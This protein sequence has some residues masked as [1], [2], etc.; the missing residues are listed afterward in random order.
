[1]EAAGY[2]IVSCITLEYETFIYILKV[3]EWVIEHDIS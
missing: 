2:Q 3:N 1:M